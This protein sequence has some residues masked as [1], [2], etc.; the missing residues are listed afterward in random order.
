MEEQEALRTEYAARENDRL[1]AVRTGG[2][3]L[4]A[5]DKLRKRQDI[6]RP[7]IE[8]MLRSLSRHRAHVTELTVSLSEKAATNTS[9]DDASQLNVFTEIWQLVA[10]TE[11]LLSMQKRA[12][13]AGASYYRL[14]EKTSKAQKTA[15]NNHQTPIRDAHKALTETRERMELLGMEIPEDNFADWG[16]EQEEA[17]RRQQAAEGGPETAA[18]PKKQAS[19]ALA[20]TELIDELGKIE[21]AVPGTDKLWRALEGTTEGRPK[22]KPK[23][24]SQPRRIFDFDGSYLHEPVE[25]GSWDVPGPEKTA[26]DRTHAPLGIIFETDAEI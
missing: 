9:H 5:W 24:S 16:Q 19:G 15:K 1:I 22:R 21:A 10:A 12:R 4:L 2:P 26:W 8:A 25:D 20:M 7:R 14:G 18:K 3:A 11:T 17:L 6:A 13:V 23:K